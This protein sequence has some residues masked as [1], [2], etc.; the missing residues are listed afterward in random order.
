MSY[1]ILAGAGG[2]EVDGLGA[3]TGRDYLSCARVG[4]QALAYEL[5]R[6]KARP[7]AQQL[8]KLAVQQFFAGLSQCIR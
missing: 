5:E 2:G 3:I 6:V 1:G 7:D 8:A 4:A